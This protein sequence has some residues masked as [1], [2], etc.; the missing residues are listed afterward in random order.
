[1]QLKS[2]LN[3]EPYPD[4]INTFVMGILVVDREDTTI[5]NEKLWVFGLMVR[6]I[7]LIE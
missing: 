3:K 1:M 6:M 5:K 4:L 2:S 7:R